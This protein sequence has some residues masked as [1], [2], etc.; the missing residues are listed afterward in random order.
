MERSA[1][2]DKNDRCLSIESDKSRPA[3]CC[4][5][6]QLGANCVSHCRTNIDWQTRVKKSVYLQFT[7]IQSQADNVQLSADFKMWIDD[8][9]FVA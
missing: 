1:D 3:T 6:C 4:L 9:L 8:K 2:I 5:K 7:C